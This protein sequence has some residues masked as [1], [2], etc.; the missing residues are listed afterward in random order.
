MAGTAHTL[1]LFRFFIHLLIPVCFIFLVLALCPD[2]IK[3]GTR[4]WD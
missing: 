2:K 3:M 1:Y 4:V